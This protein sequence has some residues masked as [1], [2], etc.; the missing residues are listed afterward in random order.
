MQSCRLRPSQRPKRNKQA[1]KENC[2]FLNLVE[3]CG[4]LFTAT[5][6]DKGPQQREG[7][8]RRPPSHSHRKHRGIG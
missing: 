8:P 5:E 7:P 1:R 2:H 4:N 6:S 3:D